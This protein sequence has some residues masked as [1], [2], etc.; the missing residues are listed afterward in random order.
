MINKR[1]KL[2]SKIS[3]TD[4]E[5]IKNIKMLW[6]KCKNCNNEVLVSDNVK[7]VLCY[8]CTSN[9]VPVEINTKKEKNSGKPAGWRFMKEFVD[10][11]GTVYHFGEEQPKLKGKLPPTDIEKIKQEQKKKREENK[12]RKER[13]LELKEK[14]MIKEYEKKKKLKKKEIEKKK[15]KLNQIIKG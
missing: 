11:D 14:R 13:R 5:K 6:M 4:F 8:K 7:Q 15:N 1:K 9:L 10:Q 12:I 3:K 2:N